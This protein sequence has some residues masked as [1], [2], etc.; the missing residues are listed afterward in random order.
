MVLNII[1]ALS[2]TALQQIQLIYS[3]LTKLD[4]VS[5]PSSAFPLDVDGIL[6]DIFRKIPL[7][8]LQMWVLCF[9]EVI[10]LE[11]VGLWNTLYMVEWF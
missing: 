6:R 5:E 11:G 10:W 1:K 2:G 3:L 9:H 7:K 8:K 4:T